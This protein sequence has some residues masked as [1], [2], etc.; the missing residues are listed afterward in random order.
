[1]LFLIPIIIQ[2][3]KSREISLLWFLFLSLTVGFL[4]FFQ[5]I[6]LPWR[7][8]LL[9][10]FFVGLQL[11]LL[12]AYFSLKNRTWVWITQIGFGAGDILFLLL[13]AFY[14]PFLNYLFFYLISLFWSLLLSGLSVLVSRQKVVKLPLA[15]L[16]ALLLVFL[17]LA[18][19]ILKINI[20]SEDWLLNVLPI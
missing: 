4:F 20:R 14:F 3:L 16:Q 17:M 13:L 12:S 6:H 15:G 5:P 11:I 10:V 7:N 19:F 9:N 18:G 2:D 1:M 8:L